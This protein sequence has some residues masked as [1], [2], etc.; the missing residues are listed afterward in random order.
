MKLVGTQ[1]IATF[2][3]NGC[4]PCGMGFF[5]RVKAAKMD[6]PTV[7]LYLGGETWTF[8]R[9]PHSARQSSV[10][11]I[12][13]PFV[14][15][16]SCFSQVL[17]AIVSAVAI[18]MIDRLRPFAGLHSPDHAVQTVVRLADLNKIVA[19]FRVRASG[20]SV[21]EKSIPRGLCM[22]ILKVMRRPCFPRQHASMG[23][24]VETF[25]QILCGR[26]ILRHRECIA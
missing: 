5:W 9:S 3:A 23:I 1:E 19:P 22:R 17:P 24:I 10:R 18:F 4:E 13:V 25:A 16:V 2:I 11:T 12:A 6:L 26:Q 7:P 15:L 8:A 20:F 14:L 21:G